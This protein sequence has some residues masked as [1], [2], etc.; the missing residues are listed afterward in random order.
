M[1]EKEANFKQEQTMRKVTDDDSSI[2]QSKINKDNGS[3]PKLAEKSIGRDVPDKISDKDEISKKEKLIKNG[4]KT[5]RKRRKNITVRRDQ[6]KKRKD[7]LLKSILRKFRKFYQDE[8]TNFTR[9]QFL[10]SSSA[11]KF[12]DA[13]EIFPEELE[14]QNNQ[15]LTREALE[16][17]S[18]CPDFSIDGFGEIDFSFFGALISPRTF[19]E[20]LRD[21]RI[22][23]DDSSDKITMMEN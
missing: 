19:K 13:L 6:Y 18:K 7:V 10:E 4:S 15:D 5:R 23:L 21:G 14:N 9:L 2:N 20:D 17:F 12:T 8:Y 11:N 22:S 1:N 3:I 16:S